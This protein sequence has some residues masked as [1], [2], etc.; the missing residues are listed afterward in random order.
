[1]KVI[2]NTRD[3]THCG[4][5][6]AGVMAGIVRDEIAMG[7]MG[8]DVVGHAMASV[9]TIVDAR[10]PPLAGARIPAARVYADICKKC[11]REFNFLIEQ[12][13]ATLPLRPGDIPIF[14]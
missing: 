4:E 5:K 7:N 10:R 14:S 1:M 6:D 9:Y 11:G 13:R 2:L 8:E 3:C 12:G